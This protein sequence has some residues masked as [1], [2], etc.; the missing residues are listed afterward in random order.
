MFYHER[1]RFKIKESKMSKYFTCTETEKKK[2]LFREKFQMKEK[3]KCN[4]LKLN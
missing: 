3:S 4:I 2:D 1:S